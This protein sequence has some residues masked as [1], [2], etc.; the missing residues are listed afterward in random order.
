MR[1]AP[2][3]GEAIDS[4]LEAV[5]RRYDS[6]WSQLQLALGGVLKGANYPDTWVRRLTDAQV[7]AISAA[8]EIDCAAI[9]EMTLGDLPAIVV[10]IDP[11]TGH[12]A[13]LFPW[14]HLHASRYCPSCLAANGGRWSLT[15][16][17]VWSFACLTHECLLASECP[18]CAGAPR[19]KI[20]HDL[21]PQR[22]VVGPVAS[23]SSMS[24][25]RQLAAVR[26]WIWSSQ[27]RNLIVSVIC[28]LADWV[29]LS[30]VCPGVEFRRS[31]RRW[32]HVANCST[33]AR[34]AVSGMASS[35]AASQDSKR[36]RCSSR[37]GSRPLCS[38]KLRRCV[39]CLLWP[40]LSSPS[41]LRGMSPQ[42]SAV[43][44]ACT[45]GER[46][47]VRMLSGRSTPQRISTILPIATGSAAPSTIRAVRSLPKAQRAHW[48]SW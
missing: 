17:T 32:C 38:S 11:G 15:W 21:V 35:F 22:R 44:R 6:T 42:E 37:W 24:C 3:P 7:L 48:P 18:Q 46:F 27:P 25:W 41:W 33:G 9:R 43:S 4:W 14:R 28:C 8:T 23:H 39:I 2:L 34:T 10:G 29:D 16:R 1:V 30:E 40:A 19:R 20:A 5:A 26:W 45:V 36:A 13:S 47:Q 12:S 31:R